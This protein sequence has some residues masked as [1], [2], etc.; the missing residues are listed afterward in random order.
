M[1]KLRARQRGLTLLELM[2]VLAVAG[3]FLAGLGFLTQQWSGKIRAGNAAVWHKTLNT[4]AAAYI[5]ANYAAL[6]ATATATTPAVVNIATLKAG[7]YL[8]ANFSTVNSYGQTGCVLVLEPVAGRLEAMV[9]GEGGTALTDFDAGPI[10]AEIGAAGGYV[11][12][13][14]N[15]RGA[16]GGW[17]VV[18][19]D[20]VSGTC[21]GTAATTGS[22][23]SALWFMDGQQIAD[24]LYRDAVPGHP[25]ANTMNTPILMSASTIQTVNTACTTNGTLARDTNGAV[26]SCQSGQWKLQT[27][28]YWQDPVAN[29]ASLPACNATTLWQTRV[30]RTPAVGTGPRAH[31]CDG[32]AWQPLA[33]D[34][35]GNLRAV[36]STV[37]AGPFGVGASTTSTVG[38][39]CAA[40]GI[41]QTSTGSVLYC[42]TN[43]L[44]YRVAPA[45]SLAVETLQVA[46]VA[47]DST[48]CPN[49]TG[50]NGRVARD[51]SG[52]LLSCQAGVWK[53]AS[54]VVAGG[55]YG[56]AYTTYQNVAVC[57]T[58]N[59]YTGWCSCPAGF[60]GV[61]TGGGWGNKKWDHFYWLC[62]KL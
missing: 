42:D 17:D 41:A 31:T 26:V 11:Y 22:I 33:V 49:G 38:A 15:A 55:S 57:R 4:A 25:E 3:A 40:G 2:G 13:A 19:T 50:D 35:N 14:T 37:V 46:E 10:A 47:V 61:L 48:A 24:Y 12:S 18:V 29:F 59:P 5:K 28:A 53:K 36:G 16:Y 43:T 8:S 6:Q 52:V 56:G 60:S 23:A 30:V 51:T 39:A 7:N 54:G 44:T 27:S 34:N 62:I 1:A 20:F 32:T 21:S 9:V 45:G 58:G